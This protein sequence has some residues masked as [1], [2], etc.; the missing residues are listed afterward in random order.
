VKI[1]FPATDIALRA[2]AVKPCFDPRTYNFQQN[3]E[4][5]SFLTTL[6]PIKSQL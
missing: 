1:L 2:L 4:I 3:Y 5:N 6:F